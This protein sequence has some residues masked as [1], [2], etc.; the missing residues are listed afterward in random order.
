MK[1]VVCCGG[2]LEVS[3]VPD[4]RPGPGQILLDVKR[5]GICGSDVHLRDHLDFVAG[6]AASVGGSEMG[7]SDSGV[8]FGH[9]F[10][11][12]VAEYGPDTQRRWKPGTLLVAMP[13]C[14]HGRHPHILG[15]SPAAPGAYAEQML[16]QEMVAFRVPNGLPAEH[17][18]LTEPMSVAWHGVRRSQID[19]RQTAYV[20]GCGPVGLATIALLKA[21][22]VRTVIAS[23]MSPRRR[24]LAGRCGATVVVDPKIVDPF[25]SEPKP[26][27][28][29][30]VA[31]M[32]KLPRT[33]W[34]APGD[35]DDINLGLDAMERLRSLPLPWWQVF[36][37]M[38]AFDKNPRG[39]VIFECAGAPGLLDR[40]VA[41]APPLS[42]IVVVGSCMQADTIHPLTAQLKEID[43][44]F[45]VGYNPGEFRDVLHMIAE[46][47]V[48]P[49]PFLTATV[50]FGGVEAAFDALGNPEGHAKVLIDPHSSETAV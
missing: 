15:T 23:D 20:I 42:R 17:A 13:M 44:R 5:A 34:A 30:M 8:I 24:E 37:A 33:P 29:T 27:R 22:G 1:A 47:K 11:G 32:V 45:S 41:D 9:E 21:T 10:S 36:R 46:G 25:Q 19:K 50:G 48:D 7:R 43:V 14:R 38:H 26:D 12:E 2:R 31:G 6:A 35:P 39:P 3:D 18:T 40:L 16:V 49:R 4:L 28:S